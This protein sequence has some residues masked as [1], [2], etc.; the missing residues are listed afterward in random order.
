MSL[1]TA[2]VCCADAVRSVTRRLAIIG[3]V[4]GAIVFITTVTRPAD[5]SE[6]P[7]IVAATTSAAVAFIWVW[8]YLPLVAS[9]GSLVLKA[10]L[11]ALRR[12]TS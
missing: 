1:S 12:V 8:F 5:A 10:V 2:S 4:L 3:G 7:P 11:V 6:W 9:L